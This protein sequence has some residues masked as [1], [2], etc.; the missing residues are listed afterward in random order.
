MVNIC[1]ENMKWMIT[2]IRKVNA[3]AQITILSPS[4]INLKTINEINSKKKYNNNTKASLYS[5]RK[6]YKAL[7]KQESVGF[8]SLL[9]AVNKPNYVDGLHPNLDGQKEIAACVWKGLNKL[10]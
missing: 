4:D 7:A 10:Y 5:L 9:H 2:E 6:R 8:V 3:T 1:V